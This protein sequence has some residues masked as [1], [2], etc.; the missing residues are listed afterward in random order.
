MSDEKQSEPVSKKNSDGGPSVGENSSD[1]K[2]P[3]AGVETGHA[4]QPESVTGDK[5]GIKQPPAGTVPDAK[6]DKSTDLGDLFIR[7]WGNKGVKIGTLITIVLGAYG[8]VQYIEIKPLNKKLAETNR[9]TEEYKFIIGQ[10]KDDITNKTE[11]YN[12]LLKQTTLPELV[13]PKDGEAKFDRKVVFK[14]DYIGHRDDLTYTIELRNLSNPDRKSVFYPVLDSRYKRRHLQLEH[15]GEYFW[16]VFPGPMDPSAQVTNRHWSRWG[17]FC[18]YN[19][20]LDR[21][22][23]TG[24]LRVATYPTYY[25]S[26]SVADRKGGYYGFDID[27]AKWIGKKF[28]IE[29]GGSKEIKVIILDRDWVE[30]FQ[31]VESRETDMAIST[32]SRMLSREIKYPRLRFSVGYFTV[33][34]VFISSNQGSRFPEDLKGKTVGAAA[35]STNLSVAE[36]LSEKFG[37]EVKV[38]ESPSY[39]DLFNQIEEGKIDF[40]LVD[41]TA[42]IGYQFSGPLDQYLIK[43]NRKVF[44]SEREEY[45]IAV[46]YE[47]DERS[48]LLKAVNRL[49]QSEECKALLEQLRQKYELKD[50]DS[51]LPR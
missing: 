17:R 38:V 43:F 18:V 36:Y 20:I 35:D 41:N 50:T 42:T 10:L 28:S 6:P 15:F 34:Q 37:Y 27:L 4:E 32:I 1:P 22:K 13:S 31:A 7:L 49:L 21:I 2:P 5:G 25:G 24:I 3:S 9:E 14:W 29:L 45:A 48:S 30:T 46:P 16:R 12:V 33:H 23:T 19:N 8:L 51:M 44:G 39:G 47:P 26:F 40:G 11:S